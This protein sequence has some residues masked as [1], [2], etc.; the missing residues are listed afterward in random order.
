MIY[1]QNKQRILKVKARKSG[2]R[3][4]PPVVTVNLQKEGDSSV[5]NIKGGPKSK[6][7]FR[8]ITKKVEENI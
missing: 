2:K 3:H 7:E 4:G 1:P 5:I 8:D 6:D